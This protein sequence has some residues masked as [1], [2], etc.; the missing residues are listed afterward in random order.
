MWRGCTGSDFVGAMVRNQSPEGHPIARIGA[1]LLS[2]ENTILE[3]RA[4]RRVGTI[5]RL[6][7]FSFR[8]LLRTGGRL[9]QELTMEP[10]RFRCRKSNRTFDSAYAN[11]PGC[12]AEVWN[13]T[14]RVTCP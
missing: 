8:A 10:L 3:H 12:L 9:Q 13:T 14:V 2:N 4:P 5:L 6:R 11:D 7:T 1:R